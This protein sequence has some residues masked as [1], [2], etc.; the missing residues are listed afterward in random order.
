[1]KPTIMRN[2]L[3]ALCLLVLA[4]A[5][6]MPCQIGRGSITGITRDPSGAVI[7]GVAVTA[8]HVETGVNFETTT[9]EAG[10]YTL[11][12]LP[13]GQYRVRFKAESFKEFVRE[14]ITLAAGDIARLDPALELGGVAERVVVTAEASM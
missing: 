8:T 2:R 10:S 1:M 13:T 3:F 7:P 11:S 6:S 9:N 14:N 5:L 4:G 12:A